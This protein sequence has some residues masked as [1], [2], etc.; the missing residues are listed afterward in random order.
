M[1]LLITIKRFF[2]M[3]LALSLA[4]GGLVMLLLGMLLLNVWDTPGPVKNSMTVNELLRD[5]K[6]GQISYISFP[7]PEHVQKQ[8]ESHRKYIP[9]SAERYRSQ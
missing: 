6:P 9:F 1:N 4:G 8:L 5:Q 3:G 7:I 2:G